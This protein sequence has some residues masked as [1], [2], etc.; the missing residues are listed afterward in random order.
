[1]TSASD[2]AG[3]GEKDGMGP[4]RITDGVRRHGAALALDGAVNLLA[5]VLIYD[6]MHGA[7][8]DVNALL[9][10]SVPPVLW[11]IGGFVRTR[12]VD[13]LSVFAMAGIALSALAFLGGG[14]VQWLQLREK[15]VTL[16]IGLAFLGSAAIGRPLIYP[17]A[18]ATMAR[19]SARALA[20]F[21]AR[22]DDAMMRHTVMV[23]TLA[24]GF[25]LLA[26]FAVSA[27]LLYL[28]PVGHYLMVGPVIGYGTIGGLALWTAFYRR[29]R[30]RHVAA[31]RARAHSAAEL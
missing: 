14:S 12:R 31:V 22:R 30:T 1:M 8:G 2:T 18:R 3:I 5:P 11:G 21:D 15:L 16:L 4:I 19:E 17:L 23:M 6:H 28:L 25:G 9:A 10:A 24:W 29:R 26:D 20:E 27:M 7:W 13:A